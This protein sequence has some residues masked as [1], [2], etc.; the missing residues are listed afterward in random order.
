MT[1]AN[2][3]AAAAAGTP[4]DAGAGGGAPSG[5]PQG[6]WYQAFQDDA[7]RG[8]AELKQ[9]KSPEDLAKSY[10]HLEKHI[11]VPPDRLL[12]LPD[13]P[14]APEWGEIRQ[15]L[16]YAPPETPDGYEL[17]V[18]A[19]LGDEFAKRAS[20]WLHKAGVPKAAGQAIASEWNAFVT[21]AA[22]AEETAKQQRFDADM[23][24]L[25]QE[26][27]AQFAGSQELA[28]R[29]Q[30]EVQAAS[31]LSDEDFAAME[32]VVGS[33]K[34]MKL[35]ALI[36]SKATEAPFVEGAQG[37]ASGRPGGMSPDAAKSRIQSLVSDKS[38]AERLQKGD[39]SA[40]QEWDSLHRIAYS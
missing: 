23:A 28:R 2:G 8:M 18:P 33:A 3:G 17:P 34:L 32:D 39:A 9:W 6:P 21:E 30:A 29:A 1:D 37:S 24:S 26:W 25:R 13:K 19:G 38:F 20:T 31:G 11:G 22:A 15:K 27:G 12:R 7:L 36:G 16:G 14:D 10:Q 40:R 5:A 35:F 4:A